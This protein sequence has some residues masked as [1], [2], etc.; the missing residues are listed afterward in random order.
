MVK[1]NK[2][3]TR[4]G[5]D[6]TTGLVGGS[7]VSKDSLKVQAYGDVDELNSWIGLIRTLLLTPLWS[8]PSAHHD[9]QS[10]SNV[11]DDSTLEQLATIQNI[12]FDIGAV[13]ASPADI[14]WPTKRTDL[15]DDVSHIE[16]WIDILSAK[17]PELRSFVLPGGSFANSYLHIARTV[18]RRAE[19]SV[20][21]LVHEESMPEGVLHYLN[22][23][24]DYLFALARF[25][26]AKSGGEEFLWNP[27]ENKPRG[28]RTPS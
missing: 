14:T 17:V 25:H 2:I 7:R 9:G 1:I 13:L 24:S 11:E 6:G 8:A 21:A 12:L 28:D 3:Y 18:C 20:V 26:L 5:D 23:L 15:T 19:R 27:G 22:R 16:H 4:T 10:Y